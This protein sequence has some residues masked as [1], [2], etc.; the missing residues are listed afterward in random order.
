MRSSRYYPLGR[1]SVLAS[2]NVS[3]NQGSRGRSPSLR[4]HAVLVALL[5]LGVAAAASEASP[6]RLVA[7]AAPLLETNLATVARML[8]AANT[9]LLP[10][11]KALTI[12]GEAFDLKKCKGI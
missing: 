11:P 3:R 8:A 9:W 12:N 4:W 5:S 6:G 10:Q 1:A 7:P 2:P